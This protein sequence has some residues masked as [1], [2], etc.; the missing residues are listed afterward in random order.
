MDID[1]VNVLVN[2]VFND[3]G[4]YLY[5]STVAD[6]A[7][8]ADLSKGDAFDE[9]DAW[10]MTYASNLGRSYGASLTE[11][12]LYLQE[13][14]EVDNISPDFIASVDK[15]IAVSNHGVHETVSLKCKECGALN[16]TEVSV[17]ALTF[18]PAVQ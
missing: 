15:F 12:I 1:A 3:Y 17:N 4:L 10:F 5:P 7:D 8:M 14:A 2:E 6:M 18:F 9:G 16:K 13:K 11:R